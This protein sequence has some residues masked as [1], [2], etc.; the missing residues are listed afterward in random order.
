MRRKLTDIETKFSQTH[1]AGKESIT[2]LKRA[3]HESEFKLLET[4]RLSHIGTWE[5][6]L[7]SGKVHWSPEI[8]RIHGMDPRKGEPSYSELL[9][10]YPNY[11]EVST[12]S[13]RE[14]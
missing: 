9:T 13:K 3:L 14:L 1:T 10:Q 5:Y 7:R 11:S 2:A 12:K 8:F 4:Q 6:D